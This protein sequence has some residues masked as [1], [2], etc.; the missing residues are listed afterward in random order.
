MTSLMQILAG[1][2]RLHA[3][4]AAPGWAQ[5]YPSR[6]VTIVVGYTPGATSDLLARTVGERL[7][8]V[9][10]QSVSST[11]ARASAATS[12][13]ALSRAR[14]RRLH[15]DGRHRRDLHQQRLSLQEH[16]VRSGEGLRADHQ[17]GRQHHLPCCPRR[18]AG[19][20]G[21]GIIAHARANPDAAVRLVGHRLPHHL[22]GELLRQKAGIDSSTSPIG[23]VA[24]PS[25]I[26]SAVISRSHSSASRP[27]CR[28]CHRQDQDVAVVEKSRYAGMPEVPP[29]A[30]PSRASNVVLAR[31]L[32]PG[33][34]AGATG[35]AAERRDGESAHHRDRQGEAR[36]A[37]SRGRPEHAGRAHRLIKDGLAVA[38][39]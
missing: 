32:C 4:G 18:P 23:A 13:P 34:D 24:R 14:T 28:I 7:N 21:G 15:A 11:T 17:C 39:S 33:G 1:T 5:D 16:P 29:S 36:H 20:I 2:W 37:R 8:V 19:Q 6:P 26:C 9:W 30:K 3:M 10:G 12:A 27:P 25:T 38:A 31:F 22:A 35:R